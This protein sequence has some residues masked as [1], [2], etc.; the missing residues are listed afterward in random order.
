MVPQHFLLVR[1]HTVAENITLG[2][3]GTRFFLPARDVETQINAFADRYGLRVAPR[4]AIW[5]L[6][7][8]EQQR[9]EILKALLRGAD[10]LIL[11]EPT[12]VLT[13]QEASQLFAVLRRMKEEGKSVIFITHKLDE[14]MAVADCV[15]VMRK[16]RV[17]DTVPVAMTSKS[18][19]ARMMVVHDVE[20]RLPDRRPGTCEPAHISVHL[21]VTC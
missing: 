14:V 4:A 8:S 17:V 16:G 3:A 10:I 2:L 12:S 19:L 11:D 9:V 18:Q 7:V 21:C 20:F 15:T 13:P 6:S 1:R 5:Q